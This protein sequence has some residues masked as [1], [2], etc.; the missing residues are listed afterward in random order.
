MTLP[1]SFLDLLMSIEN[2]LPLGIIV[3]TA[4]TK[5]TILAHCDGQTLTLMLGVDICNQYYLPVV[6]GESLVWMTSPKRALGYTR[7]QGRINSV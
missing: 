6:P 4:T 3:S 5:D 2:A 7:V 1:V